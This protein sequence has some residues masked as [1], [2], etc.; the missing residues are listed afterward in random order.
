MKM[1]MRL[2]RGGLSS[3]VLPRVQLIRRWALLAAIGGTPV[4]LTTAANDVFNTPKLSQC[5]RRLKSEQ[6]PPVEN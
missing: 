4:V 6:N 3:T 2:A 5:Q 1:P